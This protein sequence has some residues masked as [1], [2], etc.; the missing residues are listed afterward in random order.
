MRRDKLHLWDIERL[1]AKNPPEFLFKVIGASGLRVQEAAIPLDMPMWDVWTPRFGRGA[2]LCHR[3]GRKTAI[4]SCREA[5]EAQ[6]LATFL[7]SP[8]ALVAEAYGLAVPR[9]LFIPSFIG[10][11]ADHQNLA[12][13]YSEISAPHSLRNQD[14]D[15]LLAS[16]WGVT[17]E[18]I[19]AAWEVASQEL[20]NVRHTVLPTSEEVHRA[21]HG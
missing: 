19:D 9:H 4:I 3:R 21:P 14:F 13:R 15:E 6:Y 18:D 11:N 1:K 7:N 17:A 10:E 12:N 20:I 16:L 8:V 2:L 5:R